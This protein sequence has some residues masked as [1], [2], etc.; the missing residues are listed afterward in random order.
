MKKLGHILLAITLFVSSVAFTSCK[1]E[2]KKEG[3]MPSGTNIAEQDMPYGATITKMLP[4]NFPEI[5]ITTEYDN[6]FL[7]EDEA[8]LVSNYFLAVNNND[9]ELLRSLYYEGYS[10]YYSKYIGFFDTSAYL[11]GMREEMT[12]L[13]KDEYEFDYILINDCVK[14]TD[15]AASSFVFPTVDDLLKKF[16]E[17]RDNADITNRVNSRKVVRVEAFYTN[18]NGDYSLSNRY[19]ND[20]DIYIYRINGKAYIM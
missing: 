12:E 10:D 18:E 15:D 8:A 11:S 16:G 17:E 14:S 6:R 7:S 4:E 20:I 2:E 13:I 1:D 19:G 5:K 9:V 3:M